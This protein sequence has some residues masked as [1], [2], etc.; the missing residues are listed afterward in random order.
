MEIYYIFEN[1]KLFKWVNY[2]RVMERGKK[3]GFIL[4][5]FKK[6]SKRALS[7]DFFTE[8]FYLNQKRR[9]VE[10]LFSENDSLIIEDFLKEFL[11][12]ELKDFVSLRVLNDNE[13]EIQTW[14]YPTEDLTLAIHIDWGDKSQ[15]ISINVNI[16]NFVVTTINEDEKVNTQI[17]YTL[18]NDFIISFLTTKGRELSEI[19]NKLK[20]NKKDS[21]KSEVM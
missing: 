4:R 9:V 14:Y 12:E 17:D 1:N 16:E 10:F 18:L 8:F 5:Q 15:E 7:K 21:I 13:E 6:K 2:T 3:T 20:I 11:S 19:F